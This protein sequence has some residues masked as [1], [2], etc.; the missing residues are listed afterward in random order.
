MIEKIKIKAVL[1]DEISEALN[2]YG[3][4]ES[5]IA[6]NFPCENCGKKLTI[7]NIYSIHVK[8]G[9]VSIKCDDENCNS[10]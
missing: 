1:D 7:E 9:K 5:V 4:L 6:G 8:D 2:G 10:I 3:V